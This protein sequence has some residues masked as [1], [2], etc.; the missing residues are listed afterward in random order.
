MEEHTGSKDWRKE[1]DSIWDSFSVKNK[2]GVNKPGG[3]KQVLKAQERLEQLKREVK[4]DEEFN[5]LA[6]VLD[7]EMKYSLK[8]HFY[9]PKFVIIG[10]LIGILFMFFFSFQAKAKIDN[11]TIEKAASLQAKRISKIEDILKK[12]RKKEEFFRKSITSVKEEIRQTRAGEITEPQKYTVEEKEELI[13][14]AKIKLNEIETDLKKYSE[15]LETIKPMSSEE[16][17]E[18]KQK[19]DTDMADATSRYGWKSILWLIV[20]IGACFVPGFEINKREKKKEGKAEKGSYLGFIITIMFSGSSV[21]YERSDGSQFTDHSG[22]LHAF[23]IATAILL[24]TIVLYV[25]F[26]PYVAVFMVVRN[27]VIPE[28]F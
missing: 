10:T 23:A 13:E 14:K 27:I 18:Y 5:E 28:L 11:M 19:Q 2:V 25:I 9:G 22:H 6:Q 4:D 7:E 16:Y 26:L 12:D 8:R 24:T 20:L 21:R 17:R 3:R 15:E 1:I